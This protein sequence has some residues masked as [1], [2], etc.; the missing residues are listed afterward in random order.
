MGKSLS[1]LRRNIPFAGVLP[2]NTDYESVRWVVRSQT[3]H[4]LRPTSFKLRTEAEK[5]EA[6][7]VV[8]LA[9]TSIP[10]IQRFLTQWVPQE[11]PAT[12]PGALVA[13]LRWP[14]LSL[15]TTQCEYHDTICRIGFITESRAG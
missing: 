4:L 15:E 12:D 9:E 2:T 10:T 14:G 6:E 7:A 11:G 8:Q 3:R 5:D 1:T 13:Y